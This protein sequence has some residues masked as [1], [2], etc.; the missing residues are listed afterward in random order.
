MGFWS[1]LIVVR[2]R[3]LN[4]SGRERNYGILQKCFP[5]KLSCVLRTYRCGMA[6]WDSA[7][8]LVDQWFSPWRCCRARPHSHAAYF[9]FAEPLCLKHLFYH[10]TTPSQ[11][12]L[13]GMSPTA[14]KDTL[15]CNCLSEFL[16]VNKSPWTTRRILWNFHKLSIGCRIT[17]IW[18]KVKEKKSH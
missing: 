1:F 14:I 13:S 10:P 5:N 15:P 2:H 7:S 17:L 11:A 9:C 3:S 16:V 12:S 18:P 8:R 4:Q 6:Y